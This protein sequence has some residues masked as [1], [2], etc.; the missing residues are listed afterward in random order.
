MSTTIFSRRKSTGG[1]PKYLAINGRPDATGAWHNLNTATGEIVVVAD[2]RIEHRENLNGR[3]V[4]E[5]KAY[6]ANQRGWM[7]AERTA[8]DEVLAR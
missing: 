3:S 1:R 5:W 8:A 7:Q 6:V 2:G 4:T